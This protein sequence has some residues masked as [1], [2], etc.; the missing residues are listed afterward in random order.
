MQIIK[1]TQISN[2]NFFNEL[3]LFQCTKNQLDKVKY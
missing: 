1:A 2:S 3:M